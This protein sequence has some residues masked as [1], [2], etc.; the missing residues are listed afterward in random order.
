[1]ARPD[2][3]G[4]DAAV[5]GVPIREADH[6]EVLRDCVRDGVRVLF[7]TAVNGRIA[8]AELQRL[9]VVAGDD[10]R[11]GHGVDGALAIGKQLAVCVVCAINCSQ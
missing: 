3:G 9:W 1:M 7:H 10:Y 11:D 6:V 4:D 8:E 5:L 2:T